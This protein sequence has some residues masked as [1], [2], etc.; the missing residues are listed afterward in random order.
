MYTKSS[1]KTLHI[2]YLIFYNIKDASQWNFMEENNY[3]SFLLHIP[4]GK[5]LH[6][7]CRLL[8]FLQSHITAQGVCTRFVWTS[9]KDAVSHTVV[10]HQKHSSNEDDAAYSAWLPLQEKPSQVQH[11]EH[12]MVVK[13]GRIKGFRD[14][15]NRNQPLK[16]IH[17]AGW[18]V[19]FLSDK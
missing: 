13:Q 9:P 6:C 16:A 2:W 14:E 8:F 4:Y 10:T 5:H 19:F 11:E 18:L 7:L 1:P 12:G 3:E 17:C 15:K